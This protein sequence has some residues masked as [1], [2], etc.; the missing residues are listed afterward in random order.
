MA[1]GIYI[2]AEQTDGA[3]ES[4]TAGLISAAKSL[5]LSEPLTVFAIGD[6]SLKGSLSWDGVSAVVIDDKGSGIFEDDVRAKMIA[7]FIKEK[8]P[9][10]VLIPATVTAKSLFSRAAVILDIGLTADCTKI[11]TEDGK[12][13]QSKPAF[14][15]AIA[16]TEEMS[17]PAVV[18]V[19]AGIYPEE[20]AGTS[21][22]FSLY[23]A[24]AP[25]GSSGVEFIEIV[26]Q[27]TESVINAEHII[28]LG[29]GAVTGGGLETAKEL[30]KAMGAA[31]GGTRPL[32]DGGL[33]AFEQQIGQSGF[34]V[35]PKSCIFFGVSGAI[36]H[37][38]GVRD[39]DITIA[40]NTDP[41]A[42]IFSFADYGA[43]ADAKEVM[44]AMIEIRNSELEV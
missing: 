43:V 15:D 11:Y 44:E 14:G 7:R 9:A 16:V 33:M 2:Y 25:R 12:F 37:T 24:D 30:A 34:T 10:I 42:A 1:E 3:A 27:E 32:V 36:Q 41:D 26:P 21:E 38:E 23:E 19:A 18:S 22:G 17:V 39:T 35:H 13:K 5:G 20:P 31:V 40:V 8:E 6:E 28:S 4:Y 29:R